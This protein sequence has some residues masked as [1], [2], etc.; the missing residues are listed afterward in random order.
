MHEHTLYTFPFS[1]AL[2]VRWTLLQYQVP[3][4]V[5]WLQRGQDRRMHEP[6]LTAM[7]AKQKVPVLVSPDGEVLTELV[8]ILL[9]LEETYGPERTPPMRRRLIE[10]L[11]HLATDLHQQILG[12]LFDPGTP[13]E[14]QAH[15]RQRL[16]PQVLDTFEDLLSAQET[17]LGGPAGAAD[18]YL[19]WGLVLLG[20]RWPELVQR[21][22]IGA[23]MQRMMQSPW[24]LEGLTAEREQYAQQESALS[25]SQG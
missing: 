10:C 15:A 7:N 2:S 23:F 9:Y 22:A 13:P 25:A 3:S 19:M 8:G 20:Y 1:S 6:S 4:R 11:A 14:A 12:P 18:N 17:L 24:V 5:V 21:P 16:L